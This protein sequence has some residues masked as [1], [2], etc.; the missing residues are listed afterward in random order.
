MPSREEI[1]AW[2]REA[3]EGYSQMVRQ[4]HKLGWDDHK[5]DAKIMANKFEKRTDQVLALR[6]ETCELYDPGTDYATNCC[7][8]PSISISNQGKNYG[9]FHYEQKDKE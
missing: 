9:C 1:V 6:C 2:L 7:L 5:L 4:Y 3:A 8:H